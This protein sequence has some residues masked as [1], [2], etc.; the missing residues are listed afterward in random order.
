M[1]ILSSSPSQ[2][3]FHVH[4]LVLPAFGQGCLTGLM[5]YL[6]GV[7]QRPSTLPADGA[8]ASQ[9]VLLVLDGLGWDQ[10]VDRAAITPT[11]QACGGGPITTVAPSTTA[12]AL[13]SLT[14]GL[15]PGEH[16]LV[17]YR[18]VIEGEVMNSLRWGSDAWPDARKIAPPEQIQPFEPFLGHNVAM[19]NKAEFRT[20]GFSGAHLRGATLTG[21]RTIATL[22]HEVSRLIRE[23]APLVYS[24]YDGV[25]KVS[26]EYGFGSVFDAEIRFADALV[27]ALLDVLPTGVEL[28]I[29]ADHGQVDCRDGTVTI[30]DDV[31][32][33]TALSSGEGRFRWLHARSGAGQALLEA[34]TERHA[35]HSWVRS[36]EQIEDEGWFGRSLSRAARSRLGDVALCPFEPIAFFDPDD[37]GPFE[38]VGRHGSLTSAE[39]YVPLLSACA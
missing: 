16:G 35:H 3:A 36:I 23:G 12:T 13:T 22:V 25:D 37:S 14:T 32:A 27:A 18:M 15:E 4:E 7:G 17:G 5:P 28:I 19:V 33:L 31:L 2:K 26:H 11:L 6:V 38:L 20:S 24:Y 21:Y 39:M 8:A 34:S 29:T 9:R 30:D 10:L 1:S